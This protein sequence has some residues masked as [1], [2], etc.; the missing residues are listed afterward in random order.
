MQNVQFDSVQNV[1]KI[2][3]LNEHQCGKLVRT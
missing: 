3:G 2:A 1:S